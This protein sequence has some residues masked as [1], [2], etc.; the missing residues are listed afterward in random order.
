MAGFIIASFIGL[1]AQVAAGDSGGQPVGFAQ[2]AVQPGANLEGQESQG[3]DGSDG[4]NDRDSHG[5]LHG[6]PGGNSTFLAQLFIQMHVLFKRFL[7]V[8]GERQH[9][10]HQFKRLLLLLL[11]GCCENGGEFAAVV[12]KQTP[13]GLQQLAVFIV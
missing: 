5:R 9:A 3:Q 7:K 13:L 8:A 11:M 6:L 1:V 2:A 12:V 4:D 10:G